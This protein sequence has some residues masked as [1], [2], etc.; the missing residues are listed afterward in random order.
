MERCSKPKS[1]G[2]SSHSTT[3]ARYFEDYRMVRTVYYVEDDS[4]E[5]SGSEESYEEDE[6]DIVE[7]YEDP[8]EEDLLDTSDEAKSRMTILRPS[9]V[10]MDEGGEPTQPT[11][12]PTEIVP[13]MSESEDEPEARIPEDTPGVGAAEPPAKRART[14][15]IIK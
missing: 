1:A 2:K 3:K 14:F 11:R 15:R 8:E 9:P 12:Q 6:E 7:V 10:R 13:V 5:Y 4:E